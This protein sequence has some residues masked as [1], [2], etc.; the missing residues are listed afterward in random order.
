[1][2]IAIKKQTVLAT[3]KEWFKVEIDGGFVDVF[4]TLEAAEN[5]ALKLMD[6]DGKPEKEEIIRTYKIKQNASQD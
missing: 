6:N 4:S 5:Y 2:E 1:M 3:S